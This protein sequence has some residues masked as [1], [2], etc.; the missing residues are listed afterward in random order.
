MRPASLAFGSPFQGMEQ[1]MRDLSFGLRALGRSPATVV[2]AI[3]SVALGIGAN[4]AVFSILYAIRWKPLPVKDPHALV[5]IR[6]VDRRTRNELSI[7]GPVLRG[8]REHRQTFVGVVG[9][10]SDGIA[11]SDGG[12]TERVI[13]EVV[14][15]DYYSVLGVE[16]FLGRYFP[17]GADGSGWAP[18]AVLSYDFFNR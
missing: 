10:A 7:P 6:A 13:G 15:A 9:D 4:A 16:P 2:V 5:Q 8:L 1:P 18:M 11:F 12:T 3:L 14:T 17:E